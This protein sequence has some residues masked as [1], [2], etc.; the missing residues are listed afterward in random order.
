MFTVNKEHYESIAKAQTISVELSKEE[1]A[2][3]LAFFDHGYEALDSE[4]KHSLTSAIH[5][6]KYELDY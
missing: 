5:S 4:Y 2:A 3:I 1:V 6:L